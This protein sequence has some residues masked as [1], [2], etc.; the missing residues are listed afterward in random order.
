MINRTKANIGEE[1]KAVGATKYEFL[2]EEEGDGKSH[3]YY[4][5]V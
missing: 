3:A 2:N 4:F 5:D 1:N